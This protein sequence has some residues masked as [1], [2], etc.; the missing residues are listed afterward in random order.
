MKLNT[1]K[2]IVILFAILMLQSCDMASYFGAADPSIHYADR[3]LRELFKMELKKAGVPYKEYYAD[4]GRALVSWDEKYA[5][6]VKEVQLK[7]IGTPPPA[8]RSASYSL[9]RDADKL[10]A[11]LKKAGIPFKT[12][13][14]HG[15]EYII[16]PRS[17][18][19]TVEKV[20][21]RDYSNDMYGNAQFYMDIGQISKGISLLRQAADTGD[22]DAQ[23]SLGFELIS[24][25][26]IN[27]D[28]EEAIALYRLAAEQ[29]NV[30]AYANLGM[31]Y[32]YG[33]GVEQNDMKALQW[34]EQAANSSNALGMWMMG[35]F[36]KE[37][38]GGL[39][40]DTEK[41]QAWY[42]KAKALGANYSSIEKRRL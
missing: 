2:V 16:W 12:S 40:Q 22:P 11:K 31:A 27:R 24:G 1:Y 29:K 30:T 33:R 42:A 5:A 34:F 14:Y 39:E 13:R 9:A 10:K 26:H 37:G 18:K 21:D 35:K 3:G 28:M 25:K 4:D 6:E 36:Y 20:I 15:D 23:V 7:V 32:Y 19:E 38:R 41:S 8:G 17:H